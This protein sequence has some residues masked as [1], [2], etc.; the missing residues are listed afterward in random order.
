MADPDFPIRRGGEGPQFGLKIRGG[1]SA[2][3][4]TLLIIVNLNLAARFIKDI[5]SHDFTFERSH[6]MLLTW[7]K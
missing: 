2:G 6:P 4:V 7:G 3:F 5:I 1:P